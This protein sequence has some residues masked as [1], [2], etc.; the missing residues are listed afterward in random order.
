MF[1]KLLVLFLVYTINVFGQIS[2]PGLDDT[3]LAFWSALAMNQK[4][5]DWWNVS[6]F[7]GE[8]RQSEPDNLA[9]VKKQA[10]YV[11]N[12]ETMF[13][14]NKTMS[15]S[16]CASYRVQ[17][18]YEA[19][20]PYGPD[21]PETKNEQRYYLR[22]YIRER[23]GKTKLTFSLR[24][25]LRRFSSTNNHAWK[26]IDEEMRFRLKGQVS[27]PLNNPSNQ[28]MISNETLSATDHEIIEDTKHWTPYAFTEDRVGTFYRHIFSNVITDIGVMQQIKR[29]GQYNIQLAFDLIL[30]NPFDQKR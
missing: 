27:I 11:I 30:T 8:S 7:V 22:F 17:N 25:E 15:L 2:P 1:Q 24:P 16:A 18:R 23:I 10:M 21:D 28:F 3:N 4:L 26:P 9:L 6:V 19:E 12:E 5:S 14:F 20:K 29:D 13:N